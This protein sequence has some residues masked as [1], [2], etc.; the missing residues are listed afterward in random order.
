MLIK[1]Q[2]K[3]NSEFALLYTVASR[4]QVLKYTLYNNVLNLNFKF[5]GII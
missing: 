2:I 1:N 4:C 5:N 3:K